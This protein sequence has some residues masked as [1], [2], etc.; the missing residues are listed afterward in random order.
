MSPP[1]P[2]RASRFGLGNL[3]SWVTSA[4]L[5]ANLGFVVLLA[6]F[7]QLVIGDAD[8]VSVGRRGDPPLL[9]IGQDLLWKTALV[10]IALSSIGFTAWIFWAMILPLRRIIRVLRG[11]SPQELRPLLREPSELGEIARE[12]AASFRHK[13]I[14]QVEIAV[15]QELEQELRRSEERLREMSRERERFLQELHDGLIQSIFSLGLKLDDRRESARGREPELEAFLAG[16]TA[17][18]NQVLSRLRESIH[19]AVPFLGQVPSLPEALGRLVAKFDG[20]GGVKCALAVDEAAVAGLP[21]EQARE[22]HA[23]G[24]ECLMNCLRHAA[25]RNVRVS[26]RGAGSALE[27]VVEDDGRGFDPAMAPAGVGLKSIRQ[28]CAGMGGECAWESAPGQGT[29]VRVT[30]PRSPRKV[31]AA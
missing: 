25:A 31:E 23:I 28:R 14:L 8:W 18:I 5:V 2:D 9:T 20:R 17:E 21:P 19:R 6:V 27:L 1:P 30:I 16:I 12:V 22:L 4:L 15:R 3:T 29:R 13:E 7:S 10:F 24:A 11:A 26:L